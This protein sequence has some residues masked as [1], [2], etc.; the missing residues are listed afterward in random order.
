MPL[1]MELWLL[2]QVLYNIKQ[3]EKR[4]KFKIVGLHKDLGLMKY[5]YLGEL[6]ET[7]ILNDKNCII[8]IIII[9]IIL[10][11]YKTNTFI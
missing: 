8:S 5:M 6:N 3:L 7:F 2:L 10:F 4:Q 11:W 1:I 9:T